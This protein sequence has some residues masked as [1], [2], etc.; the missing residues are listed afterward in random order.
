MRYAN[1]FLENEKVKALKNWLLQKLTRERL[2]EFLIPLTTDSQLLEIGTSNR[3]RHA[4]FPN[5][6][7]SDI[8]FYPNL[9]LQYDAHHLPFSDES[10][11][12]I[13]CLEVLEHC[14]TPQSVIDECYRVLQPDGKLILTTRFIFPIHDAP[15][16]YY[17]YTKYGLKHLF[18][19]FSEV[20][21]QE[22]LQTVETLAALLQRLAYQCDWHLPLTKI[23]L[24]LMAKFIPIFQKTLKKE[25][26]DIR[27]DNV[28]DN[29]LA[30]G[31]YVIVR[32]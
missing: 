28:D 19:D 20:S 29:I 7:A 13:I 3:P 9:D 10:I 14:H 21:I 2:Q 1:L 27:H 15:H 5:T 22:E 4:Y 8:I 6:I 32:K 25:Y 17:R 12:Q 18:R 16:D 26:G 24:L 23:G 11:P 31:Y 30:S